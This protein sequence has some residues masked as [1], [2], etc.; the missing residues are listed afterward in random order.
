MR[1]RHRKPLHPVFAPLPGED[2]AQTGE[3]HRLAT[4]AAFHRNA[5]G[6]GT[7]HLGDLLEGR[8]RQEG[9]IQRWQSGK[10]AGIGFPEGVRLLLGHLS[11]R[12]SLQGHLQAHQRPLQTGKF[13]QS[14]PQKDVRRPP[15]GSAHRDVTQFSL[16]LGGDDPVDDTL[17]VTRGALEDENVLETDSAAFVRRLEFGRREDPHPAVADAGS[18]GFEATR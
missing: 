2:R 12:V 7:V 4:E 8:K 9:V 3:V 13:L 6:A 18:V 17:D 16:A 1:H 11:H 10:E 5:F 14:R 15:P